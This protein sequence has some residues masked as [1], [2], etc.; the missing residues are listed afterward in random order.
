MFLLP[1]LVPRTVEDLTV[2][3]DEEAQLAKKEQ[4]LRNQFQA[5]REY[6]KNTSPLGVTPQQQP[7]E[8]E[9]EEEASIASDEEEAEDEEGSEE[10]EEEFEPV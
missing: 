7:E 10:E 8:I 2:S 6:L 5:V 1:Q 4:E 9:P 3:V